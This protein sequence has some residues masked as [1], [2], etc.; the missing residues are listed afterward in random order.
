MRVTRNRFAIERRFPSH[1]HHPEIP[2][3]ENISFRIAVLIHRASVEGL[4]WPTP[5]SQKKRAK[6]R[7]SGDHST[8]VSFSR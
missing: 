2:A 4:L 7:Q 5:L 1:D 6:G 8:G 3:A